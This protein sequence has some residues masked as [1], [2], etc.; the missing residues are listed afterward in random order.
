MTS[1][2]PNLT[3]SLF[4]VME[5]HPYWPALQEERLCRRILE[6]GILDLYATPNSTIKLVLQLQGEYSVE[7]ETCPIVSGPQISKF[8]FSASW[9]HG[10]VDLRIN[11]YHVASTNLEQNTESSVQW[12]ASGGPTDTAFWQDITND[13]EQCR[14]KRQSEASALTTGSG[15][16]PTSPDKPYV[17]LSN[18]LKQLNDQIAAI[19]RGELY[20]D[21]ALATR[22]RAL[23]C[24]PKSQKPLLQRCAGE[25]NL[26]L[27]LYCIPPVLPQYWNPYS[28]VGPPISLSISIDFSPEK[29]SE[30]QVTMDID[31]WLQKKAARY[32]SNLYTNDEVIRAFA[33][34]E[35][36]HYDIGVEPLV[37]AL[38][39]IQRGTNEMTM[40]HDY[41]L[42]VAQCV[43][44]LGAN[45]LNSKAAIG[46]QDI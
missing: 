38:K 35:G 17:D 16:I 23:I 22:L 26:P 45:L 13:N 9:D 36:A 18:A 31:F 3:G 5:P 29:V 25:L 39:S 1:A 24:R 27:I 46:N 8:I 28:D 6:N 11:G 32:Q 43:M 21:T 33:D 37:N 20:Q 2:K 44:V 10:E 12:S 30:S 42:V 34:T 14:A 40:L 15:R 4:M 7:I 41:L 19:R